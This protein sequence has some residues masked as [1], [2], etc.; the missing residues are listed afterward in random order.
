MG[1]T[2]IRGQVDRGT[3]LLNNT[4]YASTLSWNRYSYVKDPNTG[5]RVARVNDASQW[6]VFDVPELRIVN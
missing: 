2:T 4:F 6:E 1:D 3:C 5:R